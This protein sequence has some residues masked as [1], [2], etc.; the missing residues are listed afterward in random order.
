MAKFSRLH[1]N[2]AMIETGLVP[3]FYH[4]EVDT[5]AQIVNACLE[6]GVRCIEFTNRGDQAHL[7]FGE[8]ARRF[9]GDDR[10]ILGVGSV[11]D[12]GT[13]ALYIQLGANFVVG[14]A[15]NP[16]VARLCNRRKVGYSPGCATSSEISTA[17]ELG[18]EIVKIFPGSQLGGPA[19]VKA[20]RGPMPW[21]YI[22]PTGG[23][24]PEEANIRAWFEAGVACV[25]MG[26]NLVRKDLVAAGDFAAITQLASQ[27]LA[28][29]RAVRQE[30]PLFY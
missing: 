7:V 23:V 11:L 30:F 16:E 26:S 3:L 1:V 29:I 17:E 25:G 27:S 12:P 19:F 24:S 18:V 15:L 5:A 13:A 8:L 20:I 14:P 22:M 21:T 2:Q 4:A 10:A 28:W 6:A 9:R